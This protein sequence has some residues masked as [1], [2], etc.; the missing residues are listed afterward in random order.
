MDTQRLAWWFDGRFWVSGNG[1]GDGWI[2]SMAPGAD[3]GSIAALKPGAGQAPDSLGL[4]L[5]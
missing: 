1:D 5:R 3:R 2:H 4:G